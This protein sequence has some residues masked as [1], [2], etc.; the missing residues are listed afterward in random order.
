MQV[1]V[2]LHGCLNISVSSERKHVRCVSG[3]G[4]GRQ[5]MFF[6]RAHTNVTTPL[7]QL[8]IRLL[9]GKST[10]MY[11]TIR[12]VNYLLYLIPFNLVLVTQ[13]IIVGCDRRRRKLPIAVFFWHCNGES[14]RVELSLVR[15][16]IVSSC[17]LPDINRCKQT[18]RRSSLIK[19]GKCVE[20]PLSV[21]VT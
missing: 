6:T 12:N 18:C 15:V 11:S 1:I 7:S 14:K 4:D 16:D 10:F 2:K 19:A 20:R 5:I 9:A 3:V 21:V 13:H 8:L 17:R